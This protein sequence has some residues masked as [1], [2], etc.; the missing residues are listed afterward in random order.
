MEERILEECRGRRV[1]FRLVEAE[2]PN[3]LRMR[4]DR[5]V[6]PNAVAVLPVFSDGTIL[7]ERQYR[8]VIGE[9]IVEAPAGVVDPGEE[10]EEA[11]RRELEEETGYRARKLV[12]VGRG[13][14]A[15]G[16]ST[17]MLYLY[18]APDPEPG[19]ARPEE[20]EII[21]NVRIKISEALEKI[22]KGEIRDLKTIALIYM[23]KSWLE[24]REG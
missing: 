14:T 18:L 2:L 5:V 19:E 6:F 1:V 8:P 10:P 15:P 23:A 7:L 17:E 11:A 22:S 4:F 21:S 20:H 3:G 24:S 9:Y 16:Y 13:Y 12:P